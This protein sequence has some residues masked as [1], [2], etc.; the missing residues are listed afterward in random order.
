MVVEA[1]DQIGVSAHTARPLRKPPQ[2]RSIGKVTRIDDILRM[3][4]EATGSFPGET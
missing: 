2:P 3:L 4:T 1:A